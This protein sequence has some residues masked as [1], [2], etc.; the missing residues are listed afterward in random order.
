MS[1]FLTDI[2]EQQKY[3]KRIQTSWDNTVYDQHHEIKFENP[4]KIKKTFL[5]SKAFLSFFKKNIFLFLEKY[6]FH[7]SKTSVASSF[8][9]LRQ[10]LKNIDMPWQ[11][12]RHLTTAD[13]NFE[14][15][16]C[17]QDLM[18]LENCLNLWS[19]R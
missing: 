17:K 19:Q 1:R 11:N 12:P 5:L 7:F 15:C 18:N 10:I 8:S 14:H 4:V 3:E 6:F 13:A 9:R 2:R 16:S